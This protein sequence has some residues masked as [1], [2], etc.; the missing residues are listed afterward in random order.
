[1]RVGENRRQEGR[2][3]KRGGLKWKGREG[4]EK[5]QCR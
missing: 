3:E 5:G 4:K 1:M 2:V